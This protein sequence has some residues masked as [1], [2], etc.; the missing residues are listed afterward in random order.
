MTKLLFSLLLLLASMSA[1]AQVDG[2]TGASSQV[3]QPKQKKAD[4]VAVAT[5]TLQSAQPRS[6]VKLETSKGDS[7]V[8]L[9]FETP[10]YREYF[11]RLVK[12]GYYDGILWHRVIKEFVIQ[13]GD[14]TTRHAE[15]GATV[16]EYDLDYTLPAEIRFPQYFHKRGALAAARERDDVNPDRRS[17]AAQF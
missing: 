8:D 9:Y 7:I 1:H 15:P 4:K 11:I 5:D 12:S 10:L 3:S 16:G 17:S 14:S 6:R 13:T 2:I